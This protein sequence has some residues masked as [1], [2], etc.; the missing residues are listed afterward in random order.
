VV[1]NAYIKKIPPKKEAGSDAKERSYLLND[2]LILDT[3]SGKNLQAL[4]KAGASFGT[5][6]RGLGHLNEDTK[7]I[8][9]YDFL[10]TD[11][12]GNPSAGTYASRE[13]FEVTVESAPVTLINQVKEN[14]EEDQVFKKDNGYYVRCDDG[15]TLGPFATEQAAKKAGELHLPGYITPKDSKMSKEFNLQEKI[16]EFKT[17]H[18]K[19][20]KVPSPTGMQ[21]AEWLTVTADLLAMQQEAVANSVD[22]TDL[23]ALADELFGKDDETPPKKEG[24][25]ADNSN[26]EPRY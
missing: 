26:E 21:T 24:K 13:Q 14:L 9:N 10:G 23:E 1:L 16:A 17:K 3:A 8:E 6:I 4:V 25:Q 12:V 22:T 19:E 5:S 20:G 2:W 7:E 11:A 15:T 18:F